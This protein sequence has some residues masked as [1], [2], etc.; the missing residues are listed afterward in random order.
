MFEG[1]ECR[2]ARALVFADPAF[3][4]VVD[5]HGVEVVQLFAPA[6]LGGDEIG[7]FENTQMLG[8]SLTRHIHGLAQFV[9]RLPV[10]GM[11]PVK[12]ASAPI[13][14]K[15]LEDSV[16]CHAFLY[17]TIWLHVK[18]RAKSR[19]MSRIH[20]TSSISI[21]ESDL[22]ESF[23]Q[24]GGP[25]GQNVNKVATAVQLRFDVTHSALPFAVRSRLIQLAG[26]RLTKDGVLVLTA[27]KYR[28][29]QRN[30]EDVRERLIELI[31]AATIAPKFRRPTRPTK[32][33]KER[34]LSGKKIQSQRKVLRN[35]QFDD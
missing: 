31:R 6:L 18:P 24:S 30:R 23:I 11:E 4:D 16:H 14:G 12:K 7:F 26:Q 27:R 5:R 9:E 29:Q 2:E 13:I 28:L 10:A 19:H 21:D 32:A 34:R 22:E 17:A 35:R 20:I 33:S 25:G 1:R 3:G 15:G 8:Y